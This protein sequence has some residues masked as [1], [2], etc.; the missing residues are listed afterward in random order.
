RQRN[1][2]LGAGKGGGAAASATLVTAGLGA[3]SGGSVEYSGVSASGA[4]T[5]GGVGAEAAGRAGGSAML[6]T[7]GSLAISRLS[8]AMIC[9]LA[10]GDILGLAATLA[11]ASVRVRRHSASV[12]PT[13]PHNLT[14][15]DLGLPATVTWIV[16]SN[17]RALQLAISAAASAGLGV[18]SAAGD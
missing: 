3:G 16:V 10:S 13:V 7:S 1:V 14:S 17:L 8:A 15:D 6:V 4:L 12:C 5:G 9:C 11:A 18:S 2:S